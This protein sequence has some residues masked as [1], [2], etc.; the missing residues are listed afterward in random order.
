MP[1]TDDSNI[2]ETIPWLQDI[3]ALN[4]DGTTIPIKSFDGLMS[5]WVSV[6]DYLKKQEGTSTYQCD[7]IIDFSKKVKVPLHKKCHQIMANNFD[8]PY[9]ICDIELLKLLTQEDI[10]SRNLVNLQ[11]YCNQFFLFDSFVDD[12]FGWMFEDPDLPESDNYHRFQNM[13]D[14]LKIAQDRN[15]LSKN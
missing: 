11:N 14:L 6:D 3:I 10:E 4:P 13:I 9:T 15:R 5:L 1:G 8:K 12:N 2:S 7:Q